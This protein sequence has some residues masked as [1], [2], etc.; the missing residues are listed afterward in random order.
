MNLITKEWLTYGKLNKYRGYVARPAQPTTDPMPGIVVIQEFWGLDDYMRDVTQRF[1]H[2]GYVAFAPDLYSAE[3]KRIIDLSEERIIEAKQFL[4]SI[5]QSEWKNAQARRARLT[6]YSQEK[7]EQ[8][9]ETIRKL[10]AWPEDIPTHVDIALEASAFLR[11][12]YAH[13]KGQHIGS[14][15]FCMGGGVSALLACHDTHLKGS[16]IFYG[17]TPDEGLIPQINC[18]VLGIFGELDKPFSDQV[19]DFSQSM[20]K[21]NKIFDYHIYEKAKH[22]FFNNTRSNFD[23]IASRD[24]F[25]RSLSFFNKTI[26]T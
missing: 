26:N 21:Y 2:A 14:I 17:N 13:T 4:D 11:E 22:A 5:P 3:G 20:K 6:H 10:L 25:S 8:I 7:Q 19:P 16:I 15:G 23:A 18:P 24:A 1:A 12:D 9:E